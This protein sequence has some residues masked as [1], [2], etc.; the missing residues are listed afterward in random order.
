[1]LKRKAYN[2][3]TKWYYKNLKKCLLVDGAIQIGK[4]Y[5]I[6]KFLEENSKSFVEFNLYDDNLAKEAFE[7]ADSAKDLLLKMSVLTNK[8]LIKGET[9][10]FI[11]EV[12]AV[13][14][15][16]TKVKFLVE[17]GSYRYILSGSLLGVSYKNVDSLPV[18]YM[19]VLEMFPLDFEEFVIANGVSDEILSYLKECYI[20]RNKVDETVNLQ[21]IKL[22]NLYTIV[23]G[24]PEAVDS[25]LKTNNLQNV[26]YVHE[27][28][29]KLY[30]MDI[31]K[32]STKD[33]LLIKDIYTLIPS[34]LNN[35]NKRF[36]LKNLNEKARFY[37]YEESFVWLINSNIGLFTYNIDNPEYPLLASKERTLFKLFLCDT[38][39]LTHQLYDTN[40]AKILNNDVNVNFGAI[41][42]NVIAQELKAHKFDLF[43]YNNKKR[44]EVDFI[45]E[46]G[47]EIIPIEVKSGKDYKRHVALD[48]LLS[49]SEYNIKKAYTL[50]N[51]NVEVVDNRIYIP[52][53]MI[54]FFEK[55]AIENNIIN[56]DFSALKQKRINN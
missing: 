54:M 31:S 49:N 56:F 41:Y 50:C 32:Y 34:E 37:Q 38:G 9:I 43:Y 14:D 17:E 19:D 12:Q 7:K 33:S 23:G 24:F 48:N 11:D 47:V 40:I 6:R 35:Q 55:K 30:K 13:D 10:I 4:T 46:D 21:M 52:I 2:S 36:I 29:N 27:T 1:M 22:F 25:F 20:N 28:I 53:Y 3:I 5:I 15:I 44:G 39:L 16:I 26:Y 42:E 51:G 8:P 45:I 18:G